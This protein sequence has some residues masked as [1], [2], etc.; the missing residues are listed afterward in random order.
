MTRHRLTHGLLVAATG[1]L[2]LVAAGCKASPCRPPACMAEVPDSV[3]PPPA[4]ATRP[5]PTHRPVA[6]A[7]LPPAPS[8]D[9]DMQARID[10]LR[11]S[12]EAQ[13]RQNAEIEARI[14]EMSRP[15]AAAPE[16]APV[17]AGAGDAS[18][19]ALA[20]ELKN[21]PGARVLVEG[22]SAV[23]V[24]TDSFESGSDRL[25]NNP[26]VRAALRAIAMAVSRHPSA[27]VAVTGHSD[28][29]P[30]K[31]SKWRDN[32]E[33]SQARAETVAKALVAGGA[34]RDRLSVKGVGSANP[35]VSPEKTAGDRAKNRRVE[36]EFAF[37]R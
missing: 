25:K 22:S 14:A 23:V 7:P 32:A 33:L 31:V 35:L 3:A 28:S 24:V 12:L 34:P 11:T 10:V 9:P 1:A 6:A 4:P 29:V 5:A 8:V 17:A 27:R 16:A 36:V 37:A 20:D 19:R 30:I 13:N 21:V 2:A 26:D 18:A 15:A